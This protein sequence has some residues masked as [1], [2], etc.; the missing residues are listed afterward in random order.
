MNVLRPNTTPSSSRGPEGLSKKARPATLFSLGVILCALCCSIPLLVGL[1]LGGAALT[2]IGAYVERLGLVL[3][4]LGVLGFI[5]GLVRRRKVASHGASCST[6]CGCRT[7][8][9]QGC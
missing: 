7:G 9:S 2:V 8:V 5:W 4:G 6:T 1:G 3:M